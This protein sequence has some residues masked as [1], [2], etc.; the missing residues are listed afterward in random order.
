[1]KND[2]R[3]QGFV[4]RI[5]FLSPP[6]NSV[7]IKGYWGQY[8]DSIL[9][10]GLFLHKKSSVKSYTIPTQFVGI[11]PKHTIGTYTIIETQTKLGKKGTTRSK[12]ERTHSRAMGD[13]RENIQNK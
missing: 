9:G 7:E 6:E 13:T 12:N 2:D 10:L 3:K 5:T 11:H 1:M 4:R 8:I